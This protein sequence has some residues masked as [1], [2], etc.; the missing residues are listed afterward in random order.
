VVPSTARIAADHIRALEFFEE[1]MEHDPRIFFDGR[2]VRERA[3]NR[4]TNI[5]A[6]T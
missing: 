1:V 4:N 5:G 6:R 3:R 2:L